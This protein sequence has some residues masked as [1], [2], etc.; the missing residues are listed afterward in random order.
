[1]WDNSDDVEAILR[2]ASGYV[3]AS[4][5]LRPRVLEAVRAQCSE[6]RTQN[7]LGRIALFVMLLV[8]FTVGL[9]PD[10]THPFRALSG[11]SSAAG[12][13]ELISPVSA[14]IPRSGDGDWRIVDAFTKLRR[15]QAQVLRLEI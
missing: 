1:M 12:V 13:A 6:R 9:R 14:S 2:A 5:D 8:V 10:P 15:Q 3:V 4:D 7:H 11:P